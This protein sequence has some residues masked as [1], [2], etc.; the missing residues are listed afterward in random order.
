MKIVYLDN[1]EEITDVIDKISKTEEHAV[2][3]VIPRGSTLANSVVNLK[4]LSKR[5]KNLGKHV[6]IIS[7]DKTVGNLADQV[8]VPI[9]ASVDD[10]KNNVPEEIAQPKKPEPDNIHDDKIDETDGV[11]VHQYDRAAK[12]NPV[13]ETP[14][15][16]IPT[17]ETVAPVI[18]Q[19]ENLEIIEAVRNAD[20][21]ELP[22]EPVV[23]DKSDDHHGIIKKPMT[24]RE[25]AN[26]EPREEKPMKNYDPL[27]EKI[28]AGKKK[29]RAILWGIIGGFALIILIGLYLVLPKAKVVVSVAAEP[30]STSA[31]VTIDKT[32]TTIDNSV[33]TIPGKDIVQEDKLSKPFA[34]TGQKNIGQPAKG[35][36][37]VYNN[38]DQNSVALPAGTKFSSSG[39]VQF[40]ADAAFTIPGATVGLQNGQFV[41]ISSGTIDV[42]VTATAVGDG[43]NVAAGN[44]TITSIPT[45]QQ[46]KIYGKS[47]AAMSGGSNQIVKIITDKD[48]TDAKTSTENE[49]KDSL[50]TKIKSG[51][52]DNEKLLDSALLSS[53]VSEGSDNKSGD[54]VDTFNYN[55][56]LK[57]EALTFSEADFR[58]LLLANAG[59]KLAADKNIVNNDN[60]NITYTVKS[61]DIAGGKVVLA[62]K[63]DGFIA[64]K[65]D[66]GVLKSDIKGKTINSATTKLTAVSGILSADITMTPRF[67]RTLPYLT[68]RIEIDFNYGGNQN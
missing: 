60:Q 63:F 1:D 23:D 48:L 7:G 16:E 17:D 67:F 65:F 56:D 6:S 4:L 45:S 5:G 28:R 25:V 68:K 42:N 21:E 30:F 36:I 12:E 14:A 44:F 2:S 13:V 35:K 47:S 49:L 61:A 55:V 10:A 18:D 37:T 62:G 8:G 19:A 31:D 27:F 15:A 11:K 53:I 39:G 66:T 57:I 9:F 34:P 64:Q 50:L 3:L 43:G 41:I 40:S 24:H 51:L 59:G 26:R 32:T 20:G 58:Q 54:Q 22:E 33:M 29:R 46:S 38:W 52:A